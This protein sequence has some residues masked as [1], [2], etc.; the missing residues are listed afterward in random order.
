[1]KRTI[2]ITTWYWLSLWYLQTFLSS[3][4][5]KTT[6]NSEF[7]RVNKNNPGKLYN[8]QNLKLKTNYK[9]VKFV[10]ACNRH[11]LLDT[12][13]CDKVSQCLATGRWFSPGPLVSSTNK[14]DRHIITELLLKIIDVNF[15]VRSYSCAYGCTLMNGYWFIINQAE[16]LNF[17]PEI[18][19]LNPVPKSDQVSSAPV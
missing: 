9:I 14:T 2:F 3:N 4:I 13:L 15:Y 12:I 7:S 18:G 8:Y 5:N 11:H 10:R 19:F 17:N 1:M 16:V 6:C